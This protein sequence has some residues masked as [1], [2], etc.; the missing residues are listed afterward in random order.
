[1]KI[2]TVHLNN[3]NGFE[4][5]LFSINEF[6]KKSD[7]FHWLI[8]DGNSRLDVL[9]EIKNSIAEVKPAALFVREDLGV[10]DAM[11]QSI[12]FIND[13]DW[14]LFLNAGDQL[15]MQFISL[16]K[17]DHLVGVDLVFSDLLYGEAQRKIEAPERI[18]FAYLLSKTVNHQSLIIKG[19]LIKKY[20]F[21]TKYS[22]VADWVQLFEILKHENIKTKKLHYP[23]CV[24]E[25]GGI[26]EIQEEKRKAERLNYLKT[27]YSEWE[28]E[29]LIP[30]S[31]LRQRSY[32]YFIL[33]SLNSPKRDFILRL[34][35]I[36]EK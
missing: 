17:I 18:D 10:Y 24:Y 14:V 3:R 7:E 12:E 28:L 16:F 33:K 35:S 36:L 5:T 6:S 4:K 9:D 27:I 2:I 26:S 8:K 11:N 30:L 22:I 19:K 29:G 32:F 25:G 15:S 34:I 23:I 31:K 13:D 21:K 1:M 20:A